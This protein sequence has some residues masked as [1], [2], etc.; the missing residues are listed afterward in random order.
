MVTAACRF[1]EAG[2]TEEW[3]R[4]WPL[5]SHCLSSPIIPE[6][7]KRASTGI[8]RIIPGQIEMSN[9]LC[10]WSCPANLFLS[11]QFRSHSWFFSFPFYSPL[12]SASSLEL[13]SSSA[14]L[15]CVMSTIVILS[16][17]SSSSP[18]P[19]WLHSKIMI[20][21]KIATTVINSCLL[22]VLQEHKVLSVSDHWWLLKS[23]QPGGGTDGHREVGGGVWVVPS[24]H[25]LES[26]HCQS[27]WQYLTQANAQ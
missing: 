1:L 3:Q 6:T 21:I 10:L 12:I 22:T 18:P 24:K 19:S 7:N 25:P 5:S 13:L 27:F 17:L 20:M 23:R 8:S 2:V 4:Q 9:W 16:P 26:L 15:P 11:H 14:L